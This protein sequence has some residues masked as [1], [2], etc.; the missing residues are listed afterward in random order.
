MDAIQIRK[1]TKYY[2]KNRGIIELDFTVKKGEFLDLS[3]QTGQENPR[4]SERCWDLFFP[5]EV[6]RRYL[7]WMW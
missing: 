7:A 5:Q 3:D 1:L 4:Q 2:G 6:M